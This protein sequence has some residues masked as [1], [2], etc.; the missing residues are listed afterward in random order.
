MDAAVLDQLLQGQPGDLP[1]DGV[2]AG[3][4]DHLGGVVDVEIHTGEGLQGADVAALAADDAALHLVIG[5]GYH[6]DGGFRHMVRGAAL[7]GQGEDLLGPL[8]GLLLEL[9]LDLPH[10][11]GRLVGHFLGQLADQVVLGLLGGEAGDA[12]QHLHLGLFD[13]G[14]LFPGLV[15]FGQLALEAVLLLFN[16]LG[17]AVQVLFLLL[18]APLLL[19][20]VGPALLHFPFVLVAGLEDLLLGLHQRLP[21]LALGAL[22][23]LVDDA[24]GL[25]LRAGDLLLRHASAV[26]DAEH[27]KHHSRDHERDDGC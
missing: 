12:L 4:G 8:V 15:Q 26:L 18:Q 25:L 3:D 14:R 6:R 17:L 23:G 27:K 2:E 24:L 10:L 5:Q 9:G 13:G 22:D 20:Q 11:H 19:L 7:D 16:V 1:A 21:L